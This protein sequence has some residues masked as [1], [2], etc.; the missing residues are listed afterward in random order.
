[1]H[2]FENARLNFYSF[3]TKYSLAKACFNWLVAGGTTGCSAVRQKV[4]KFL[5]NFEKCVDFYIPAL[6]NTNCPA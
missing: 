4:K 6:Y 3:T 5:K 1:M 2:E